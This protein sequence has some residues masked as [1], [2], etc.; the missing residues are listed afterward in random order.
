MFND[1]LKA[2]GIT[3]V[4]V[5][6]DAWCP[7]AYGEGTECASGCNPT[8]SVVDKPTLLKTMQRDFR[9]RAQRRAVAKKKGG[10]K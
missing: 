7:M 1:H 5:R 10:A 8:I 9:N 4:I 2:G 6:H 3:C